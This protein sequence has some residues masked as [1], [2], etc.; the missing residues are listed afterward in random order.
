MAISRIILAVF[1]GLSTVLAPAYV[2]S[3]ATKPTIA[4]A[5][6]EHHH[7]GHG[8]P[9]NSSSDNKQQTPMHD[10]G[11][12]IGCALSCGSFTGVAF[13]SIAYAPIAGA[14]LRPLHA[15][16][17]IRAETANPPFRPPRA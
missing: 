14:V 8:A 3:A 16:E 15:D 11:S 1:F 9:C 17:S 5:M 13:S 2:A 10:C 6:P 4:L 7:H 12:F